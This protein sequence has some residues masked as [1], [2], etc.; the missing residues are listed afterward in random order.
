MNKEA[1]L[2][3]FNKVAKGGEYLNTLARNNPGTLTS[4]REMASLIPSAISG[5]L[6]AASIPT[7]GAGTA[8]GFAN[9]LFNVN[10]DRLKLMDK[11]ILPQTASPASRIMGFK[12]NSGII[13][14][15]MMAQKTRPLFNQGAAVIGNPIAAISSLFRSSPDIHNMTRLTNIQKLIQTDQIAQALKNNN[16]NLASNVGGSNLW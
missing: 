14:D 1:F 7:Y 6:Q 11:G 5:G 9:R 13:P 4:N 15:F 10:P 8:L 3:G 2:E 12:G 16:M